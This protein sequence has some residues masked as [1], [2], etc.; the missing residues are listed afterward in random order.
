[1]EQAGVFRPETVTISI[2]L[3]K[4]MRK[5]L[6]FLHE[7]DANPWLH[8]EPYLRNAIRRYETC[9]LPLA[10]S[11]SN[12]QPPL[13]VHW[14]WHVHM[15]APYYYETDCLALVNT[16]VQ[17]DLP[18]DQRRGLTTTRQLWE[19][20]YSEP[21]MV[22]SQSELD[23]R[24]QK[25]RT[26]CS[27]DI[28]AAVS[29][30]KVFYYQVSLPHYRDNK[31]LG[32]AVRRYKKFL[33][34]KQQNP[35]A[36]LVPC[37][38]VDLAW[39]AH[40]L[41]PDAYKKDTTACLGRMFNHDDNV[42]D[43][44]PNSKLSEGDRNTR[45]LWKA[46]FGEQF[47]ISGAMYRGEP[48]CGKLDTLDEEDILK[49]ST[50]VSRVSLK[51]IR[52]ENLED[53][54]NI[55]TKLTVEG[56]TSSKC[57]MKHRGPLTDF[58]GEKQFTLD[59]R[60]HNTLKLTVKRKKGL[61]H[62]G[63]STQLASFKVPLSG[64]INSKTV[65]FN[66]ADETRKETHPRATITAALGKS[67]CRPIVLKLE[68]GS[69]EKVSNPEHI[70]QLWRPGPLQQLPPGVPNTLYVANHRLVTANKS[71]YLHGVAY[72]K[73]GSKCDKFNQYQL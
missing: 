48:P 54:Q 29:R 28:K 41:R 4:A 5:Q 15:L 10:A 63:H 11:C 6:D 33:F 69:F 22:D 45:Q 61:F 67:R 17:H 20:R 50:N 58:A 70:E 1:M 60:V 19:E 40:Q 3:P 36:F 55:Q 68:L 51:G 47:A 23:D 14:V 42:G 2:D 18:E 57:L 34:L 62:C 9:W 49:L 8:S 35:N 39:H 37:Y 53:G 12:L 16:T 24:L 52:L 30:Q 72:H 59:T 46:V 43:R 44:S 26:R 71:C 56:E 21:F 27:Y 31:F 7:V 66:L 64:A 65:A 73:Y 25:Y 13:D 32:T 38:D